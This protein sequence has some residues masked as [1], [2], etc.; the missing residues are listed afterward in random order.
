[1]LGRVPA[2]LIGV[3][4][5]SLIVACGG[6]GEDPTEPSLPLISQV[7]VASPIDTLI[8]ATRT[9]QLSASAVDAQGNAIS[10]VQYEW[11]SSNTAVATVGNTGLVQPTVAGPVTISASADGV[12]GTLRLRVV[13]ADLSGITTL[14]NDPFTDQLVSHLQPCDVCRR[15]LS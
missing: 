11:S 8:A 9:V 4:T 13:E 7:A 1:M 14:L 15:L 12:S 2:C 6:D 3:A 5:G 10:T